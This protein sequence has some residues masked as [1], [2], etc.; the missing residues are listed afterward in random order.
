MTHPYVLRN[1]IPILHPTGHREIL[2]TTKVNPLRTEPPREFSQFTNDVVYFQDNFAGI[3]FW[4]V[5]DST[6]A[7]LPDLKRIIAGEFNATPWLHPFTGIQSSLK[8][9]CDQVCPNRVAIM[10]TTVAGFI[11]MLVILHQ[12]FYVV[13]VYTV[14]F[15]VFY[16]FG[17]VRGDQCRGV[18]QPVRTLALRSVL[19]GPQDYAP[20]V[21]GFAGNGLAA[22]SV[23]KDQKPAQTLE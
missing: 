18:A 11:V 23:P 3:G 10:L 6:S 1:I 20:R 9:I 14:G 16:A 7:D 4:P 15:R 17:M 5:P 22:H 21:R 2:Q 8:S 13:W 12:L 19:E